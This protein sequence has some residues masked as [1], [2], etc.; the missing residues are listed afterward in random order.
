MNYLQKEPNGQR[1]V[2]SRL[3][4]AVPPSVQ[5]Q[6]AFEMQIERTQ[7]RSPSKPTSRE[8]SL[9]SSLNTLD[10]VNM[11][12]MSPNTSPR[13]S[14]HGGRSPDMSPD[15]VRTRRATVLDLVPL[16]RTQSSVMV[17]LKSSARENRSSTIIESRMNASGD[18][19]SRSK[20]ISNGNLLEQIMISGAASE[21]KST[22][23][24]KK[25]ISS[26]LKRKKSASDYARTTSH[27]KLRIQQKL[28]EGKSI[29]QNDHLYA[30]IINQY[31][32]FRPDQVFAA[33][34]QKVESEPPGDFA[35]R[36]EAARQ[37]ANNQVYRLHK[38]QEVATTEH[39]TSQMEKLAK[40]VQL[41]SNSFFN[42]RNRLIANDDD[43]SESV[44]KALQETQLKG[45]QTPKTARPGTHRNNPYGLEGDF[46]K[47]DQNTSKNS[48]GAGGNKSKRPLTER[49]RPKTGVMNS[50]SGS[51]PG[52]FVKPEKKRKYFV[53]KKRDASVENLTT[54]GSIEGSKNINAMFS[55]INE[56]VRRLKE[57]S[58]K[59]EGY[60]SK[61]RLFNY[62]LWQLYGDRPR[63]NALLR[64]IELHER[65]KLKEKLEDSPVKNLKVHFHTAART[66]SLS[67]TK[68]NL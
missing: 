15:T 34:K 17:G 40:A 25:S 44:K 28:E 39:V 52:K 60:H 51:N 12:Q 56:E 11:S 38:K 29:S 32:T 14:H 63:Q 24:T 53:E 9:N 21:E 10:Q 47:I 1:N 20:R 65:N 26:S 48:K 58:D 35:Q 5:E 36:M 33:L 66:Y 16:Q 6:Q 13:K 4:K 61:F 68:R 46:S 18:E 55:Y 31:N 59:Q 30:N 3:S 64:R 23:S 50:S 22:T 41:K 45:G 62:S 7:I 67:P 37:E 43:R 57:N 54:E 42:N 2:I 19:T 49:S 8:R 27:L